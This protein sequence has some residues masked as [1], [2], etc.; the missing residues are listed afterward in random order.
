MDTREWEVLCDGCGK[1]CY[2]KILEGHLW[3]KRILNTRIACDLLDCDTCRCTDYK[4]RFERQ[5][6]CIKLDKNKIGKFKWLPETC[7]YR[8][9]HE[10]KPLP[11]WHPLV[12]GTEDSLK[13]SGILIEN[14]INER[15]LDENDDWY[16]YIID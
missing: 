15:C 10:G 5:K 11:E 9:I 16:D 3:N 2:R 7:A 8:L 14:G 6:E 12:S 13:K 4:H 1:C